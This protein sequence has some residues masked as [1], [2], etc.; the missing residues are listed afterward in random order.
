MQ[1]RGFFVPDGAGHHLAE[2]SVIPIFG[3]NF[4]NFQ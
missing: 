4:F 3:K 1:I 2:S